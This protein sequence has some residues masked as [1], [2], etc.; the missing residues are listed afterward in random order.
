MQELRSL[1]GGAGWY[2]VSLMQLINHL[3]V[4]FIHP[5]DLLCRRA[6]MQVEPRTS[7]VQPGPRPAARPHT[8]G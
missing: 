7:G 6:T 8:P 1:R 2:H 3:L 5:P 4:I